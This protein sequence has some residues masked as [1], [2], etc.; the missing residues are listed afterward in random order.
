M[1]ENKLTAED[2]F[3]RNFVQFKGEYYISKADFL[4]FDIDHTA[5]QDARIA[6]LESSLK[7]SDECT[8]NWIKE[9]TLRRD[10]RDARIK[11]L[12]NAAA[13]INPAYEG[14]LKSYLDQ[15]HDIESLK[16]E[17]EAV[18]KGRDLIQHSGLLWR[19]QY[20]TKVND[21]ATCI[22][23]RDEAVKLLKSTKEWLIQGDNRHW[24]EHDLVKEVQQQLEFI[25]ARESYL[26]RL[27]SGETKPEYVECPQCVQQ[28][29]MPV[30]KDT[31]CGL[32]NGKG[33]ILKS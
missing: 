12:E 10:E 29:M 5:A 22:N 2:Y 17:L 26:T 24:R 33:K 20:Q 9:A 27:S 6:E 25:E 7:D 11:E 28:S 19:D 31:R 16:E 30:L 23:Q 8:N 1:S 3:E 18:K 15:K 32:C 13:I 14:I 21:L 4:A